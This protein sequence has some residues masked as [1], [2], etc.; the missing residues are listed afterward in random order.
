MSNIMAPV[1]AIKVAPAIDPI[2]PSQVK[3]HEKPLSILVCEKINLGLT[4]E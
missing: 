2:K 1:V 4:F 3:P